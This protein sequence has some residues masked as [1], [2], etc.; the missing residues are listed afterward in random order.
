MQ[1]K[2]P[3]LFDG[4]TSPE[5]L[6]KHRRLVTSTLKKASK[7]AGLIDACDERSVT[8]TVTELLV[9]DRPLSNLDKLHYIV[10]NGIL[11]AAIR[12]VHCAHSWCPLLLFTLVPSFLAYCF[13]HWWVHYYVLILWYIFWLFHDTLFHLFLV[14]ILFPSFQL[15][16]DILSNM[17]EGSF[18]YFILILI[19]IDIGWCARYLL[20]TFSIINQVN[21]FLECQLIHTSQKDSYNLPS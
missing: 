10:G 4:L 5:A 19:L 21:L 3:T 7:L 9:A 20:T 15:L 18:G 13:T 16:S 8:S 6:R 2:D 12:Y 17:Y 14:Q 1:E 11:R